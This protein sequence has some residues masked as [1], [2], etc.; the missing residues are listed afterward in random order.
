MKRR[1][2]GFLMIASIIAFLSGCAGSKIYLIDLKYVPNTQPSLAKPE[3][4]L[5]VGICPFEDVRKGQKKDIIGLRHRSG[6]HVDILKVEGISLSESVTQATKDYFIQAGYQVIDCEGWDKSPEG[7]ARLPKDLS[8]VVGGKIDSFAVESR[9]GVATTNTQYKLKIVAYIGEL[10]KGEVTV[11][12]TE[13]APQT[14]K[15][16]FKVE[17]IT[18][19]LNQTLSDVVQNLFR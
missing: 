5:T 18:G 15:L 11:R 1:I 8:L 10:K 16:R 14:K 7:L 19:T 4:P 9:S 17:E 12:T 6:G 13:S 2:F 3:T